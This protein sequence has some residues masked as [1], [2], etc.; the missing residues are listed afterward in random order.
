M[1]HNL[2]AAIAERFGSQLRCAEKTDIHFTR[3]NRIV[4]G[5]I[6]PSLIERERLAS[7]LGADPAWLFSTV[8]RIPEL[9]A[10]C[11]NKHVGAAA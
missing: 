5:W 11:T 8:T 6:E 9:P 10:H 2:R 1:R 7:A 4:R 3:L